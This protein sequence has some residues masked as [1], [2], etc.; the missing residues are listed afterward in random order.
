MSFLVAG[1][2]GNVGSEVV[3]ALLAAG[4]EVRALTRR[5]DARLP[6]GAETVVGD[7]DKPETLPLD[8]VTGA[9][10]LPGYAGLPDA[11]ALMAAAGVERV[12]LLSGGSVVATDTDN[13]ISRYMIASERAVRESGLPWTVI[14]PSGFMSN[15]LQWAAQ[16]RAGDVVTA[17]FADVPIAVID[18]FDVGAVAATALTADGPDGA[19]HT[20]SGPQALRPADR[21][22]ILGSVLGRE[23]AFEGQSNEDAHAEMAAAMP[24]EYVDTFFR[25]YVDGTLDE[26][27][28]LPTVEQVTGRAPRTFEQWARAHT[29]AFSAG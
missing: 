3:G 25:F 2:T 23:L 17:A 26:S 12:V 1:A 14:R 16:L 8:G 15:T 24:V 7:L 18:P 29:E 5:A 21:V 20:I 10:L 22:S 27:P 6:E 28:V 19:V 4:H 9:F 11:L 13:P